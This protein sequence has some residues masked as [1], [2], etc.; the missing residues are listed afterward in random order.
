M[1]GAASPSRHHGWGPANKRA[2]VSFTFDNMGEAAEIEMGAWPEDAPIGNHY[3]ARQVAPQLLKLLTKLKASFFIEGWNC[4]IYPEVIT[5]I[6]AAGHEIGLHGWRHEVWGK[7]GDDAQRSIV[8]RSA[9]A[10]RSLG[11]TPQGF[12][13]PGGQSSPLLRSLLRDEGMIYVSDVGGLPAIIDGVVRLPFEWRGVDGVFLEP[14]LGK[15]VGVSGADDAGLAGM[16]RSHE[17]AIANAIETGGHVVFVFHPFLLGKD[18][19]RMEALTQLIDKALA[20]PDLWVT[21]CGAVADWMLTEQA[22]T[23]SAVQ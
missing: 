9:D 18:E 1:S 13:P 21:S 23:A 10:M 7:L 11:V 4:E 15:A 17:G 14:D 19:A 16:M 22:K 12:R 3:S 20:N 8:R 5:S 2:V 6:S